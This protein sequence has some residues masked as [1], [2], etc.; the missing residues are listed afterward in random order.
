MGGAERRH[1]PLRPRPRERRLVHEVGSA[2]TN[3]AFGDPVIVHPQVTCGFCEGCRHGQDMRCANA[4]FPG[5]DVDGGFADLL[6]TSARSLVKLDPSL[7][8]MDV[9]ALADA[10]LTAYH[11]ARKAAAAIRPG[12]T[13]VV[14]GAG[15]LGHIGVQC[16]AALTPPASWSPTGPRPRSTWP[17][18]S[19]PMRRRCATGDRDAV[20]T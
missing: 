1:A 18:A 2:V 4:V 10:G 9:A 15:G 19:G 13:A 11:A 5:L 17:P 16:Q 7:A 20:G 12:A 14:I 3:V 8:P 6:R